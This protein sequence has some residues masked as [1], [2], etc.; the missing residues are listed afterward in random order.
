[1]DKK[2]KRNRGKKN[3]TQNCKVA[4]ANEYYNVKLQ[5][6]AIIA[7]IILTFVGCCFVLPWGIYYLGKLFSVFGW[8]L[9][10]VNGLTNFLG[11]LFGVFLGF[12]IENLLVGKLQQLSRYMHLIECL[13]RELANLN[14]HCEKCINEGI[15]EGINVW[16]FNDIISSAEN[17]TLFYSLPR[18]FMR[19]FKKG[20]HVEKLHEINGRIAE[21]N[22]Q[23]N[24]N[25]SG[26]DFKN[27]FKKL[28]DTVGEF[29]SIVNK[30]A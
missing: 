4:T 26:F 1:M 3:K 16:T 14:S 10:D 18:Y 13:N 29:L 15:A 24:L 5:K 2:L 12:I 6:C 17:E 21:I 23:I 8:T 11:G 27:K 25:N 7:F 19:K 30:N 22:N 28:M 9:D 20:S